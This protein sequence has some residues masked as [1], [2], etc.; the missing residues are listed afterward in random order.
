MHNKE[1]KEFNINS[2]KKFFKKFG[3]IKI[4]NFFD[5][6]NV[7]KIKKFIN[8][9]I[10]DKNTFK[11]YE[12]NINNTKEQLVRI[13]NFLKVDKEL[14]NYL[15]KKLPLFLNKLLGDNWKLLKEKINFK[16]PL[17]NKDKLHQDVQ[18]GWLKYSKKFVSVL[19][20]INASNSKNANLHLDISGNN[21]QTIKGEEFKT[22]KTNLLKKP[23]FKEFPLNSGD[24]LLFNGYIPHKSGVNKTKKPRIQVYLTYTS[25]KFIKV[26]D[27]YYKDKLS[28]FPPNN[29]RKNKIIYK[30]LV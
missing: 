9:S 15:T 25:S 23:K 10:K 3:Y 19:I 6:K 1:I 14:D 29:F 8:S 21:C 28:N 2:E 16:P 5:K 20:S 17:A 4:D 18:A 7:I 30:Y 22:L 26:R 11:Y 24:T 27:K 12:Y 13:E